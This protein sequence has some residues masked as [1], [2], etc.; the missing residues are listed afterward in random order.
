MR[1]QFIVEF[2]STDF[3][4]V[5]HFSNMPYYVLQTTVVLLESAQSLLL[6]ESTEPNAKY[7]TIENAFNIRISNVIKIR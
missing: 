1:N 5:R 4:R 7:K 6:S 2:T 3:I